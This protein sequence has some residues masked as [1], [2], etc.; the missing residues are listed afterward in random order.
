MKE[1]PR[2]SRMSIGQTVRF[3]ASGQTV[4]RQDDCVCRYAVWCVSGFEAKS[5]AADVRSNTV[6]EFVLVRGNVNVECWYRCCLL[7]KA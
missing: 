4:R 7:W 1:L 5:S 2:L 6:I 3:A